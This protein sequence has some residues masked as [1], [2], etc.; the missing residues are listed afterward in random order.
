MHSTREWFRTSLFFVAVLTIVSSDSWRRATAATAEEL[1]AA[2]TVHRDDWGVPHIEGPTDESAVFGFAYC[3]AEDFFWQ[4]EDTY[5]Q[6][7]GRYAEVVGERGLSSDLTNHLF[8]ISARSK[9]D[10]ATI[11]P[12]CRRFSPPTRPV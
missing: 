11:E 7:V 2:V 1:A 10:F 6:C 8:E 9:A 5:L 4:V 12:S 3:Q